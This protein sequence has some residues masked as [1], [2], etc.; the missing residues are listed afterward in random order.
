[1]IRIDH[2]PSSIRHVLPLESK[3]FGIGTG[4]IG[5]VV[6]VKTLSVNP[7]Y[8]ILETIDGEVKLKPNKTI[9]GVLGN[10]Q[11][12]RGITGKIPSNG[13]KTGEKAN[14][15]NMGGVIGKATSAIQEIGTPTK[16]EV[17]GILKDSQKNVNIGDYAPIKLNSSLS[18]SIPL[19]FVVGSDM[20][21][22]KTQ[23]AICA[24]KGAKKLGFK[25]GAAKLTGVSRRDDIIEMK[26]SGA[27]VVYDFTDAGL[28]STVGETEIVLSSAKSIINS[29]NTHKIDLIIAELGGGLLDHYNVKT[30]LADPSIAKA[31]TGI[32]ITA[33][34]IVAAWGSTKILEE[35]GYKILAV[36]GPVTDNLAGKNLV[37][38]HIGAHALN[39]I[40]QEDMNQLGTIISNKI[41]R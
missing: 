24:I 22:G 29:L 1:M 37:K 3:N 28:P 6:L 39:F 35:F 13:I 33:N 10:R 40:F 21:T 32:V 31:T 20:N 27:D 8:D 15:L 9:L 2:I 5:D 41:G 17:I 7:R 4:N 26:K 19:F 14:I 18:S 12:T 23:A 11:G 36:M 16:V 25:V 34:D 38:T 30:I